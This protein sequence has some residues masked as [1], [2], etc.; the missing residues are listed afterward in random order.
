MT[1]VNHAA[2]HCVVIT[3]ILFVAL[4]GW[5]VWLAGWYVR[6]MFQEDDDGDG[7]T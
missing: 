2:Y 6:M 4:A 3:V 1:G 5:L 7:N